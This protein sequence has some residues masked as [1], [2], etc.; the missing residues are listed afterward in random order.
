MSEYLQFPILSAGM[1][2]GKLVEGKF[3]PTHEFIARF[4]D[5]FTRGV[6]TLDDPLVDA[7][8]RGEDLRGF[9]CAEAAKGKIYAI[10]DRC[11]RNLGCGKLLE[12]RLK[13]MLPTHLF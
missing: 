1:E 7:W 13:N 9:N 5:Q 4:G 10:R 6:L 2:I 11:G 12:G 8:T 3:L